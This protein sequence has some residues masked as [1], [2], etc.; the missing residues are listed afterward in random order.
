MAMQYRPPV[1][2]LK[3]DIE[4]M[5]ESSVSEVIADACLSIA[6]FEDDWEWAFARLSRVAV[7]LSCPDN[8][9]S[10]AVTCIGHLVR[11]NKAVDFEMAEQL[12]LRLASDS[13]VA[14]TASHAL[15]DLHM[16]GNRSANED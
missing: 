16:F 10:L 9:R 2:M 7:D 5:L 4:K 15:D 11:K 3:A 13:V 8:L 1:E 6:Y 12:L 14:G